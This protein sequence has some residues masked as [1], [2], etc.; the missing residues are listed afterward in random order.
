ME[1]RKAA[2]GRWLF[3]YVPRC[4]R[5]K[6]ELDSESSVRG[7][8][9]PAERELLPTW[10]SSTLE[11]S[12]RG[13]IENRSSR[14]LT[15]RASRLSTKR[16]LHSFKVFERKSCRRDQ[17]NRTNGTMTVFIEELEFM[18]WQYCAGS[19]TVLVNWLLLRNVVTIVRWTGGTWQKGKALFAAKMNL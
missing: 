17:T 1:G 5:C 3:R 6:T 15:W 10:W 8:D 14:E 19:M 18:C 2:G 9:S 4:Y 11:V 7:V 13:T 12:S 16:I